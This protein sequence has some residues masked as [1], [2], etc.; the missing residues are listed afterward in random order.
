M[1]GYAILLSY[2]IYIID[3]L[4]ERY[5]LKTQSYYPLLYLLPFILIYITSF[6][7]YFNGEKYARFFIIGYTMILISFI[8]FVL[9]SFNLVPVTLFTVYSFNLGFLIEVV[10]LSLA[11]GDRIR[12]ERKQRE[13]FQQQ[14][15]AQLK[16]NAELKNT[17]ISELKEKEFILDTVNKELESKVALRTVDLQKK[18]DE[19]SAFNTNLSKLVEDLNQMNIKLDVDNWQL[20]QQVQEEVKARLS[21]EELSTE[22][23]KELF[24]DESACLRYLENIKWQNGFVCKKCGHDRFIN[25]TSPFTRKCTSCKHVESVTAETLFHGIRIPMD[26][27][28]YIV[29][30]TIRLGKSKTLEELSEILS[31]NKN[32]VWAFR[33]K[34]QASYEQLKLKS[35]GAA[36][37]WDDLLGK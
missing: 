28:F 18:T 5:I 26:K 36:V 22:K 37:K 9:R 14:S 34:I 10:I 21:D 7:I 6:K 15:I 13:S 20:K 12:I 16:E 11:L 19:L 27:A 1:F 31:L 3:F 2:I 29:Y 35:K 32:T 30:D 17:L 33:K 24:P 25:H 8:I 4:I 23:F